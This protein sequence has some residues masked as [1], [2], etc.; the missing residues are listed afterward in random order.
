MPAFE[1]FL[2]AIG[3]GKLK[4]KI[5][6]KCMRPSTILLILVIILTLVA[7]SVTIWLSNRSYNEIV[8]L[9]TEQF[10][11]QQLILARS[12]A[13]AIEIFFEDVEHRIFTLSKS[14]SVH[15]IEI[16]KEMETLYNKGVGIKSLRRLD[17]DGII[18]YIYPFWD[19]RQELIGKDYSQETYFQEA[20]KTDKAVVSG[21]LINE[22]GQKR[23]RVT[24]PISIEDEKGKREFN[25]I[26]VCSFDPETLSLLYIRPIL[27]GKTGYAWLINE[28]GIFIAHYEKGFIGKDAFKVLAEKNP[29]LF[30]D[31]ID[32]IQRKMMAEEQGV[33]RYISGWHQGQTE[34]IEKLI[35]YTPIRVF[36][37]IWSIAVCAPVEEVERITS[38]AH[39]NELLILGF[40]IF[41][42]TAIG[43]F[44]FIVFYRWS[45][46]LKQEI[47]VR[48]ETEE[49]LR[50]SQQEFASLF[51]SSPEALVYTDEKSNILD[52]NPRFTKLFGYTLKE[53][54][55]INIDAGIIHSPDKIE[56]GK[57]LG[58]MAKSKGLTEG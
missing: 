9:A 1:F 30:Y 37:K 57:K 40:N 34:K 7:I 27:S 56:E 20:K 17:K 43:I 22:K 53:I 52:V 51:K 46:S 54:K 55:G 35:A 33:G 28:E 42:L 11:Q 25:G 19:W 29:E 44:F 32:E 50:K 5:N 23:I 14:K 12:A 4:N 24:I 38:E 47:K 10:S 49:A 2:F 41:F 45:Q 6:T 18:R 26:I 13:T 58:R 39:R 8:R 15:E 21:L 31:S 36:D 3:D 16:L 48:K